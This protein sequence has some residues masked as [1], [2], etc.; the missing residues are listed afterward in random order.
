MDWRQPVGCHWTN[1]YSNELAEV[2]SPFDYT[3]KLLYARVHSA[4]GVQRILTLEAWITGTYA[5][6]AGMTNR[7]KR[8]WACA[9][10]LEK[11]WVESGVC[12]HTGI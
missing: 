2:I 10:A 9:R 5:H 1:K 8:R 4:I 7:V 6:V 12:A 11:H 3:L